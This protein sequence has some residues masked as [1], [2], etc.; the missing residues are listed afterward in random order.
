MRLRKKETKTP[1]Q[2]ED[3]SGNVFADLGFE[4]ANDLLV[5]STLTLR[6][7]T[8]ME[9][10]KLTETAAAKRLGLARSDLAAALRGQLDR[11]SI[12]EL[13]AFIQALEVD[14]NGRKEEAKMNKVPLS[15]GSGHWFDLGSARE[16]HAKSPEDYGY[17]KND[18]D[19]EERLYYT[20]KGSFI[21]CRYAGGYEGFFEPIHQEHALRWLISNGYQKDVQQL[22]F[23]S[24]ERK[25]EV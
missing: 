9:K 2:F 22:E 16:F 23:Q 1:T 4:D 15:D 10:R 3:S 24:E 13:M 20:Q 5:K 18:G 19:R 17:Q 6:I 8:A 14:R 7:R 25:L 11:F 21:L 12:A